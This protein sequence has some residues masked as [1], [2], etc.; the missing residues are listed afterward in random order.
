MKTKKYLI[1]D[2]ATG[3]QIWTS[4][5]HRPKPFALRKTAVC[6]TKWNTNESAW[7]GDMVRAQELMSKQY[8]K[9]IRLEEAGEVEVFSV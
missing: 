9:P 1:K 4:Y 8:G 2:A 5:A 6:D 7:C 3:R